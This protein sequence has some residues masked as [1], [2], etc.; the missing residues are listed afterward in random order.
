[1]AD[2]ILVAVVSGLTGAVLGGMGQAAL[3]RYAAFKEAQVVAA[4]IRAELL[5]VREIIERRNYIPILDGIVGRLRLP[6]EGNS[7]SEAFN[8]AVTQDYLQVFTAHVDKLG[9]LGD[10]VAASVV[11]VYTLGKSVLEDLHTLREFANQPTPPSRDVLLAFTMELRR[12]LGELVN[13]SGEVAK[14]LQHFR[15][16]RWLFS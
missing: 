12:L 3:T 1:M 4:S 13:R 14:E 2:S 15:Q 9:T 16:R 6:L 10:D 5:A 11:S 8:V 7:Y